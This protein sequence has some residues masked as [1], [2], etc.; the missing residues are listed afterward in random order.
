MF[1]FQED[2]FLRKGEAT[3]R[4]CLTF[5]D[6]EQERLATPLFPLFQSPNSFTLPSS[7]S[8]P[9]LVSCGGPSTDALV[10]ALCGSSSSVKHGWVGKNDDALLL[11]V[12]VVREKKN[13]IVKRKIENEREWAKWLIPGKDAFVIAFTTLEKYKDMGWRTV[14]TREGEDGERRLESGRVVTG[15]AAAVLERGMLC[16]ARVVCFVVPR[17]TVLD[18]DALGQF[19]DALAKSRHLKQY[20]EVS[21]LWINQAIKDDE[22]MRKANEPEG[23]FM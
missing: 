5:G 18:Y 8:K 23:F 9:L 22:R 2:E 6:E 21:P 12:K 17:E 20:K 19:Q 3:S 7:L 15:H 16:G 13:E 10:H 14:C 1:R 11:G 4:N